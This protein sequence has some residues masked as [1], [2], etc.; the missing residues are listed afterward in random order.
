MRLKRRFY[1]TLIVTFM[2]LVMVFVSGMTA[3]ASDNTKGYLDYRVQRGDTL[4]LLSQRFGSS[5]GELKTLNT[6]ESDS[7]SVNQ[8]LYLPVTIQP[9]GIQYRV[10]SGDTLYLIS[11][12]VN[13]TVD[14][15]RTASGLENVLL[16]IGQTLS[17]PLSRPGTTAY[18]VKPGDSLY[19]IAKSYQTTVDAL[20]NY[21]YLPSTSLLAGQIIEIPTPLPSP[22]PA[23]SQLNAYEQKVGDLVNAER[24]KNGLKPLQVNMQLAQVARLK[25]SDMRDKNYFDHQSPTYGSPFDM[26]KAF[27]ITFSYAGENL[28]AG[29]QTPEAVMVG[30]MNS[31]GHRANI[32]NPNYTQIG[33]GYVAGGS[34]GSYWTQEFISQ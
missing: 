15:I 11:L 6:L 19:V 20:V 28:A 34:Y 2:A 4:W 31:S 5:T 23:S 12:R 8:F 1:G 32:L 7:V 18:V 26:M 30:W 17:L 29:Y 21:N 33:V 13:R 9:T 16:F 22:T 27:G 25:S 14:A 10:Q 24:S 3:Y